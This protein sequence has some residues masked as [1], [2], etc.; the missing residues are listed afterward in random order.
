MF[1]D[2]LEDTNQNRT[3]QMNGREK[4]QLS[5]EV[6][7]LVYQKYLGGAKHIEHSKISRKFVKRKTKFNHL[8]I[9][10]LAKHAWGLGGGT[11]YVTKLEKKVRND[12]V[13][14][15]VGEKTAG[16]IV[17]VLDDNDD[18][19][20]VKTVI[21]CFELASQRFTAKELFVMNKD[22]IASCRS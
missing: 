15:G 17:A 5:A 7:M 13:K 12:A 19:F 8:T 9:T 10:Y 14:D 2:Q 6:E 3:P 20:E 1:N 22:T 21:D 16:V 4:T 18:E 11:S